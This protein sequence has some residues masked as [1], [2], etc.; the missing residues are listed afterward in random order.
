MKPIIVLAL[1]LIMLLSIACGPRVKVTRTSFDTTTDLSGRWND[2]D[3]GLV[4]Q[5]MIKDVLSRV[6]Y[7]KFT[8]E[9]Q[10]LPVVIVGTVRN[11]TTEH[12]VTEVFI[13]DME[14]ELI[15][16]NMVKFVASP[17]ERLE[18]REERL[19]QQTYS[20]LETAK[21]LAAETGADFM[22]QGSIKIIVDAIQGTQAKFYQTDLQLIHLQTNEKVWIGTKKIKKI[23]TRSSFGG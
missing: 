22:L 6:W 17:E 1:A 8:N 11:M 7:E 14:R 20:S 12:I 19:D 15:N 16:S 23:V 10:R 5:E 9:E 3:A 18:I 13:K 2:T 21:K 4:A